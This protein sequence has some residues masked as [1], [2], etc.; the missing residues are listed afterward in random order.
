MELAVPHIVVWTHGPGLGTDFVAALATHP[1]AVSEVRGLTEARRAASGPPQMLVVLVSPFDAPV[2]TAE[3]MLLF[4]GVA[5][6]LVADATVA[7]DLNAAHSSTPVEVIPATLSLEMLCWHVTVALSRAARSADMPYYRLGPMLIEVDRQG[8]VAT[9][10]ELGETWFF[11]GPYPLPGQSVLPLVA[12]DDLPTFTGYLERAATDV[13]AFFPIRVLDANGATHPMHVGVRGVRADQVL[14]TLQPLIDGAPIVGHRLS[15]RDPFTGLIDRWEL[16]R[17]MEED[18]PT[19]RPTFVLHAQLDTF[20]ATAANLDFHQVDELFARVASAI[21]QVFPWPA[22]PARLSG[23]GFLLLVKDLPGPRVKALGERL[24]RMVS[25]IQGGVVRDSHPLGLSLGVARVTG[26]DHDLAVRLAETAAREAEALGGSRLVLA[27][28]QTLIRSRLGDLSASMD[29][30]SW[31]VWLQPVVRPTDR[32]PEFHEALARFG[33]GTAAKVSRSEFF[34]TGQAAGLLER[35]D[36]LMIQKS[37]DLLAANSA[38][39][40]SVNVTRET[41]A[42]ESFPDFFFRSLEETKVNE[43]RIIIEISPACLTL[44]LGVVHPRLERLRTAGIT[45]ALDDFGSGLCS[46]RHL[47][48]FPLAMIKL[49]GIVTGYVVDDP[50]QRNFVRMVVNLC[51]ARGIQ[52][53]AEYIRTDEQLEQ[54]VADGIDLFQG[55][56]FGMPSPPTDYLGSR[57]VPPSAT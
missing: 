38:L 23:G 21:T 29:L 5:I 36:R 32:L 25:R 56:L 28:P 16:W 8:V 14:L 47:T 7:A 42:L 49:D 41:F 44:P 12:A 26:G 20:A 39:R 18:D 9:S 35:F 45:V 22:L 34:T 46:L 30:D 24:I 33:T 13:P 52:T 4:P 27:G 17:L 54:L 37:L 19:S 3:A 48:D 51:R 50:L 53:A 57:R 15:I 2:R 31:D 43:D 1:V 10:C 55:E 6:L 40:L 11:P